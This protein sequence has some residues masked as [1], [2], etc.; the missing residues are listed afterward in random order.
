MKRIALIFAL[1]ATSVSAEPLLYT[2]PL[3]LPKTI[4][5]TPLYDI[6]GTAKI[7][8]GGG[9]GSGAI[10]STGDTVLALSTQG[11]I[12][13]TGV[14][15]YITRSLAAD[16]GVTISNTDGVSGNPTV[17]IDTT[18][19][20]LFSTGAANPSA[21]CTAGTTIFTQTTTHAAWSVR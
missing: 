18:V 6:I 16:T 7:V 12:V 17:G 2:G 10:A 3:L 13:R 5:R 1:F 11:F 15:T 9:A 19:V 8:I 14:N 21:N 20:P 4:L